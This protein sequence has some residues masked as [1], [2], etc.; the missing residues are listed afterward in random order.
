LSDVSQASQVSR[1]DGD[2][3]PSLHDWLLDAIGE[4][5][6][7][8]SG[9][10]RG[11][12]GGE[13]QGNHDPQG[14]RSRGGGV[15][16]DLVERR[17]L[18]LPAGTPEVAIGYLTMV[19]AAAPGP[20]RSDVLSEIL[21]RWMTKPNDKDGNDKDGKEKEKE[22]EFDRTWAR[23]SEGCA[24]S[25]TDLRSWLAWV[26]IG[27]RLVPRRGFRIRRPSRTEPCEP[28]P[29]FRRLAARAL[30]SRL[31]GMAT[32]GNT[33]NTGGAGNIDGADDAVNDGPAWALLALLD[34]PEVPIGRGDRW[35]VLGDFA[36]ARGDLAEAERR[37]VL[38]A[39][40]SG[41]VVLPRLAYVKAVRARALIT[42]P[43]RS[44]LGFG[45]VPVLVRSGEL[46]PELGRLEFWAGFQI[47][48]ETLARFAAS[49][50]KPL[51]RTVVADNMRQAIGHFEKALRFDP[52]LSKSGL[53]GQTKDVLNAA[54]TVYQA[55]Q[56]RQF[57]FG[58]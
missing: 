50:F 41:Q 19:M 43:V 56:S 1:P 40:L 3:E 42:E 15:T 30:R 49:A 2:A 28:T 25:G 52:D 54:R 9:G 35:C 38:G 36:R 14:K 44:C 5:R 11:N 31:D 33:G 18:E 7:N 57:G 21:R 37:Y 4:L 46:G 26:I 20:V 17:L 48:E 22:G 27:R 16:R 10:L 39:L 55:V 13:P 24:L 8:R 29:H 6:G 34:P 53:Y 32:A 45:G 23:L 58:L 47:H 51:V 12:H